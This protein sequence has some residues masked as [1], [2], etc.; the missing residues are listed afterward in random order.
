MSEL[1]SDDDELAVSIQPHSSLL[2]Q[3][4][5]PEGNPYPKRGLIPVDFSSQTTLGRKEKTIPFRSVANAT[6]HPFHGG[7]RGTQQ[8]MPMCGGKDDCVLVRD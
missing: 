3:R 4:F 6:P 1:E 2:L 8:M 5:A 7:A